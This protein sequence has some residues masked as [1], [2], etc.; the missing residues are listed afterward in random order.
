[1]SSLTETAYY[2]RRAVNWTIL[3]VIAY[4]V[5][6]I[7]W[8]IIV[9]IWLMI[10][11]P[12]QALPN[13]AF[14]RLPA[15]QFP[16]QATP[17]AQISYT[18]QTIEGSVPTASSSA[19]VYFMPK[20]A[21]NLLALTNTEDF[22]TKMQFDPTPIQE[23][24][25]IYR[26]ND[27]DYPLRSLRY[28]I[29]SSNFIVRYTFER[30]LSIFTEKNLPD[31][32]G[33]KTEATTLLESNG[34]YPS[35][36]NGGPITVSY[37]KLSGIQLA[38]G[39][40]LSDSDA[41]RVD[42]FRNLIGDTPVVAPIPDEGPISIIISGSSNPRKRIIQ[43]AYTYWPIDYQT[44]ATYPLITSSQ[45]WSELQQGQGYIAHYPDN[46]TTAVVRNVYL[47][48]YDTYDPQTYLQPVFVF[49]GDNNFIAYVPAVMSDW[50]EQ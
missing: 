27:A 7:L 35:D 9:I 26:F 47:A 34:L 30:D 19:T 24:K 33:A 48:Y 44:T 46:T 11:P 8:S 50:I 10:F 37:L 36:F 22:A 13:H 28:D 39:R 38:P 41:L 4:F 16:T 5:L 14:G 1:M 45:A 2:T 32:N 31:D 17:S 15:L 20:S 23:S 25:N 12:Q 21:A 6:R 3:G 43:F 29:V 18:L 40:S 42:F 49:S